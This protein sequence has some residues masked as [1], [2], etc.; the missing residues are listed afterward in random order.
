MNLSIILAQLYSLAWVIFVV[1]VIIY[2][3]RLLGR[4]V[5][6]QERVAGTLEAIAHNL[7]NKGGQ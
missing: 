7:E 2:L 4:F 6:A 1:V 3:L 5:K